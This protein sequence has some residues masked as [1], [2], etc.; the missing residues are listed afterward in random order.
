MRQVVFIKTTRIAI[1]EMNIEASVESPLG[2]EELAEELTQLIQG[3]E[4]DEVDELL[5]SD[6]RLNDGV[7]FEDEIQFED[8]D[9]RVYE[10]EDGDGIV[11]DLTESAKNT[12]PLF[13][14]NV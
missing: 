2:P 6:C 13:P 9:V 12:L 8:V 3:G 14:D 4:I 7:E 1:K 11:N 10:N 5:G